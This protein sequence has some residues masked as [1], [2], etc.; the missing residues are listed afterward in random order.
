MQSSGRRLTHGHFCNPP[1]ENMFALVGIVSVCR[2]V[3]KHEPTHTWPFLCHGQTTCLSHISFF[4]AV[5]PAGTDSIWKTFL[6]MSTHQLHQRILTSRCLPLSPCFAFSICRSFIPSFLA[7]T[8][9]FIGYLLLDLHTFPP[10]SL[11]SFM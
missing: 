8:L 5:R 11:D 4:K 9:L 6:K 3:F 10:G 1:R 7:P 2:Y